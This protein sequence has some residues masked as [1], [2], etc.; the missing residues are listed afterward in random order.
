MNY[1]KAEGMIVTQSLIDE[2]GVYGSL[3][4]IRNVVPNDSATIDRLDRAMS[5]IYD[6]T[7]DLKI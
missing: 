2:L 7:Q 1:S 6:P 4:A 3:L 5:C